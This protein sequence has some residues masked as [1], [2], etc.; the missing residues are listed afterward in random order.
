MAKSRTSFT[1]M[2]AS[3]AGRRG[4]RR[5]LGLAGARTNRAMGWQNL[6]RA[7]AVRSRNAEWRRQERVRELAE[8]AHLMIWAAPFG[9]PK[10][11]VCMCGE[12]GVGD[13]MAQ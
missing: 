3:K 2:S 11:W 7:R 1:R 5:R 6:K 12:S 9:P 10:A 4:N 8:R 13:S